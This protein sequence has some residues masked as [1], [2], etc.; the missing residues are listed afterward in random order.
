MEEEFRTKLVF[1]S[2][3]I[4]HA[5]T[6]EQLTPAH[7]IRFQREMELRRSGQ[8]PDL[9]LTAHLSDRGITWPGL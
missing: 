3:G 7:S 9:L 1:E 4:H 6:N 2:D 5:Q 8:C